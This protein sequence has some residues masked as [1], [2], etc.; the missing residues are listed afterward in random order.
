MGDKG[1]GC[2]E[3]ASRGKILV[4]LEPTQI[5]AKGDWDKG[6]VREK[7]RYR[8]LKILAT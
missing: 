3:K 8:R 5:G 7:V 2:A 4:L 1:L 6:H